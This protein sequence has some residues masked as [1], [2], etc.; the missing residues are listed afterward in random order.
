MNSYETIFIIDASL[1]EEAVK[2]LQEKFTN[3]ISKNG[4]ID[5]VDEWGKRRLAYEIKDKTEGYYVLVNF[6]AEPEFPKE[7]DR[8][9]KITDGILRTIIIRKDE[10]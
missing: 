2:A 6:K 3:L 5:S 10:E 9:Y 4:T 7:L 1:E 8:Q